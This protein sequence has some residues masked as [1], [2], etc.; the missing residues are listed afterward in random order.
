VEKSRHGAPQKRVFRF[1]AAL[2]PGTTPLTATDAQL[3]SFVD[4]YYQYDTSGGPREMTAQGAGCSSCSGGQGTYTYSFATNP[5]TNGDLNSWALK[6]TTTL[7]DGTK[8]HIV[9]LSGPAR[10]GRFS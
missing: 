6:E 3:A 4:R 1:E 7:P 9:S 2:S 5:N 10:R 8:R